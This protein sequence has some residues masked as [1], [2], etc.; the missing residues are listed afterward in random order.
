MWFKRKEDKNEPEQKLIP[1][2]LLYKCRRCGEISFL[3]REK[4]TY[5]D[6]VIETWKDASALY[7][8]NNLE[9]NRWCLT[10]LHKCEK[11]AD[12]F[13]LSDLIGCVDPNK[14]GK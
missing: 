11:G 6:D 12:I 8:L 13:G 3:E 7:L 9:D 5:Y 1:S 2:K 4:F 14:K 10:L